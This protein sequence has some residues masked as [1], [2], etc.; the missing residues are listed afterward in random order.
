MELVTDLAPEE[1]ERLIRR[2]KRLEGQIRGIQRMI[3]EKRNCHEIIV[4]LIAV[5]RG[6]EQVGL[7]LLNDQID[8]CLS[9]EAGATLSPAE[10]LRQV[11]QLWTRFGLSDGAS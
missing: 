8:R 9:A 2:L 11:L 6:I 1:E 10:H 5:R 4:Q 7:I 3:R